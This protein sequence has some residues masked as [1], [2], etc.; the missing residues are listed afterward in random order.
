MTIAEF[1][2]KARAFNRLADQAEQD[3]YAVICGQVYDPAWTMGVKT[4][5]CSVWEYGDMV[6]KGEEDK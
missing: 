1:R 6:K 4:P 3:G 2:K 5:L